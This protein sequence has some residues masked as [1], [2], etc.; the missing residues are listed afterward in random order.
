MK[1]IIERLKLLTGSN[2]DADNVDHLN[3][4]WSL[5]ECLWG[6]LDELDMLSLHEKDITSYEINQLR[7]NLLTKWLSN[8]SAHRVDREVK[9]YKYHK[10][11]CLQSDRHLTYSR[12]I[13]LVEQGWL[14][15]CNIQFVE[16]QSASRIL[17][18]SNR[19]LGLSPCI[20]VGA[21]REQQYLTGHVQRTA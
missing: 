12:L 20:A 21:S 18:A 7:K 5:C 15:K 8:V 2:P 14:F 3:A 13:L 17:F 10:V 9:L 6:D 1:N 4:V 11:S 19:Q 16:W